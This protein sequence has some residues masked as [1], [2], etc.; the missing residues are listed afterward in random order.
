MTGL[1]LFVVIGLISFCCYE[2]NKSWKK[3]RELTEARGKEW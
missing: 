3:E 2:V 1:F